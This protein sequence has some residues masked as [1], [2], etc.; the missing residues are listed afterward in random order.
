MPL[1][2]DTWPGGAINC[3]RVLKFNLAN[4]DTPEELQQKKKKKLLLNRHK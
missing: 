4:I 2:N 1:W 3:A